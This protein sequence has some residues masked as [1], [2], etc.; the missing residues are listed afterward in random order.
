MSIYNLLEMGCDVYGGPEIIFVLDIS[1]DTEDD[2]P[3][4]TYVNRH[5]LTPNSFYL[6]PDILTYFEDYISNNNI[7]SLVG[8]YF[9][10]NYEFVS[11][12]PNTDD[13]ASFYDVD[14]GCVAVRLYDITEITA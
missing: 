10:L 4:L 5:N 2:S 12:D 9:R 8:R 3:T 6:D 13:R 14:D 11:F 7:A 1:Q